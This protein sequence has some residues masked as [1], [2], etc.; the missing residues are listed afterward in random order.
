MALRVNRALEEAGGEEVAAA[1][2]LGEAVL[3]LLGL[4]VAQGRPEA[5]LETEGVEVAVEL[6][7]GEGQLLEVGEAVEEALTELQL[8][9]DGDAVARG[10]SVE[11]AVR[12]TSPLGRE[13]QLPEPETLGEPEAELEGAAG[14]AE[15]RALELSL[16][17]ATAEAELSW[18]P[19]LLGESVLPAEALGDAL[20]RAEAE[21]A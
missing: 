6:E 5:V 13:L 12:L 17:E 2:L 3:E 11:T 20:L 10:E 14:L 1:L 18:E 4:A 9:A 8:L 21:P 16:A 19:G 15:A 7:E